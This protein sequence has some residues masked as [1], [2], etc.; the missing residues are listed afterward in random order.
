MSPTASDVNYW[1]VRT[2]FVVISIS[3]VEESPSAEEFPVIQRLSS[4]R[5]ERREK[6][7]ISLQITLSRHAKQ[8]IEKQ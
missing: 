8:C 7:K 3:C 4:I 2:L 5:G 6:D 1:M